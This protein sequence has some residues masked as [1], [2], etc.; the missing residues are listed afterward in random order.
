MS[1]P[2]RPVADADLHAYVDGELD[3]QQRAEVEAHLREDAQV[4][5]RVHSYRLQSEQLHALFDDVLDE[6][7]PPAVARALEKPRPSPLRAPALR[8]AAALVLF[9]SGAIAGWLLHA[10]Q[11]SPG[12]ATRRFAEQ[13]ASAYRVYVSEVR[14]PV[15]VGAEEEGHLV[16]WLSKRLGHPVRTPRLNALGYHL[17]GGRLLPAEGG[18][19][20]AQFMYEDATGRRLTL[21]VRPGGALAN[22]AFRFKRED[23]ISMFYWI[24]APFAYALIGEIDREE[25]LRASRAVYEQL[26][27]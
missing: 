22:A 26:S 6:P 21:Y 3:E 4:A 10:P 27:S 25:L 13:A 20:A 14:H 7:L 1:I 23:A 12:D 8:I 5:A 17:V 9:M 2:T 16:A 24:D 15:E 19:P 11:P 18:T